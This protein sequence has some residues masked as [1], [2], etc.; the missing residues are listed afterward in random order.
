MAQASKLVIAEVEE[1]VQNG[2]IDSD[3]VHVPGLFVDRIYKSQKNEKPLE[4][5]NCSSSCHK[6][7]HHH[8]TL[9]ATQK[10]ILTR[11]AKEVVNGSYINLGFGL[12]SN[13]LQFTPKD[14]KVEV[15]SENGYLG[16]GV[17]PTPG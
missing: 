9:T 13:L 14:V 3:V 1:I 11:V 16:S 12:P 7:S 6:K 10:K 15:L 17:H 8:E 5:P 2:D 4:K